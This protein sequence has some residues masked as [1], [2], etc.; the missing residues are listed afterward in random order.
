M[1]KELAASIN[2][3]D[4]GLGSG[5]LGGA[6]WQNEMLILTREMRDA[7]VQMSFESRGSSFFGGAGGEGGGG[8]ILTTGRI[9]SMIASILATPLIGGLLASYAN[10]TLEKYLGR[11][12]ILPEKDSLDPNGSNAIPEGQGPSGF[13]GFLAGLFGG[14]S[15]SDIGVVSEMRTL[16]ELAEDQQSLFSEIQTINEDRVVTEQESVRLSEIRKELESINTE[17]TA[18]Q[19]S[20]TELTAQQQD[21]I[22]EALMLNESL[23]VGINGLIKDTAREESAVSFELKNQVTLL[24][25]IASLKKRKDTRVTTASSSSTR[26]DVEERTFAVFDTPALGGTRAFEIR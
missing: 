16:K 4:L 10:M 9:T 6:S 19:S 3:G 12:T 5:D 17:L 15:S 25:R 13:S 18:E 26:I 1:Q 7:L 2:I 22:N 20:N 24:E 14:G 21:A 11:D 23:R 8:G